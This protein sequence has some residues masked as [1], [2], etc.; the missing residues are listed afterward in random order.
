MAIL[1][2]APSVQWKPHGDPPVTGPALPDRTAVHP[3]LPAVSPPLDPALPPDQPAGGLAGG[4][5]A[6]GGAGLRRRWTRGRAG[7]AGEPILPHPIGS[8]RSPIRFGL[9]LDPETN[10]A[11]QPVRSLPRR[12]G[13]R[14]LGDA[15]AAAHR[16]RPSSWRW[17]ASAAPAGRA[18][19]VDPAH[20]RRDAGPL[21]SRSRTDDLLAAWGGGRF[22]MRIFLGRQASAD[23]DRALQAGRRGIG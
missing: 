5:R 6:A 7:P 10:R 19:A 11:V 12:S 2:A 14:L 20:H 8:R 9:A 1:A 15:P 16:A 3:S 22:E 4:R 17:S 21:P 23:G 13:V 18:G